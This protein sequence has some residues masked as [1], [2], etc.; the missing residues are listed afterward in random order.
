[1]ELPSAAAKA[2]KQA[3]FAIVVVSIAHT[4]ALGADR[5]A[6]TKV[7]LEPPPG[8]EAE[9]QFP[10][11]R[12]KETGASIA[13]TEI[14]GPIDHLRAGLT[15]SGLAGRGMTLHETSNTKLDGW[16]A[17]LIRVTQPAGGM[18]FEKWI[19][20]FGTSANSVFIVATYPES[21]AKT[22]R[23]MMKNAIMTT[24]WHPDAEVG[25]FEG[26]PFRVTETPRLRIANRVSNMVILTEGGAKGT[27][28]PADPLLVVGTSISEVSLADLKSF[29]E[30]RLRQIE[31]VSGV[32][33]LAGRATTVDGLTAYELTGD[34]NDTRTSKPLRVYQMVVVDGS[35]Y[36]LAQ[37]LVGVA[38][39][40]AFVP[41]FREVAASIR[42]S[43]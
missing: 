20:V 13:V 41:L 25:H 33:N 26:L 9:S 38:R 30:T 43:D 24:R 1:M 12:Q 7:S 3:I 16:D 37:G 8:F 6:G 42:R 2:A 23:D 18:A 22:L 15:K 5:I 10:G 40:D 28:A 31:Q 14:A 29:S 4:A 17:Q 39:A 35:R 32:T 27:V 36:F 19:L 11:F 34:A 21:D